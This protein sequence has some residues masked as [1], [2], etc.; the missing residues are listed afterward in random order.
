[1]DSEAKINGY[2]SNIPYG[3]VV[4]STGIG[5]HL[6]ISDFMKQV[7]QEHRHNVLRARESGQGVLTAP[8][9]LLET[10]RLAPAKVEDESTEV[11]KLKKLAEAVDVAEYE[12]LA[13]VSH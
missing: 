7:C 4:W 5:S 9:R 8:F 1:M 12:F 6:V 10:Y 3:M 2:Q 11:K 13:T